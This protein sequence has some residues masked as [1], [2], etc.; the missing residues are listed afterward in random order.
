MIRSDI[1]AKPSDPFK[2][3][4]MKKKFVSKSPASIRMFKSDFLERLSKVHFIVPL[5][6][7]TPLILYLSWCGLSRFNLTLVVFSLLFLSG[8]FTWTLTEYLLHR[9]IFHY[10]PS[11]EYGKRLHFIFHGVHHDYPHDRMRLVMPPTASLPLALLFFLFFKWILPAGMLYSFFPGFISGYLVYDMTHYALHH[12][13]IRNSFLRRLRQHHLLHH[14]S[15][16]SKGFGVSVSLWDKIFSSD[17][18]KN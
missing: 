4:M 12:L 10:E 11:S 8:F 9:F 6:V 3:I 15:D 1:V 13:N 2:L 16:S 5:L 14:Y 17:F 7:Y 18:E